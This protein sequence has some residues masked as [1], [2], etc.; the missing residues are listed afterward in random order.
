VPETYSRQ[1]YLKHLLAHDREVRQ[2][3]MAKLEEVEAIRDDLQ[4]KSNAFRAAALKMEEE[5]L[6]LESKKEQ[7]RKLL[8]KLTEQGESYKENL[9][10]LTQAKKS[11]QSLLKNLRK[12]AWLERKRRE[13][14]R[15]K[16]ALSS[17]AN[18][19]KQK[20][21]LEPPVYGAISK[22]TASGKKV[23]GILISAPW[24]SD[25]RAFFDGQVI[26]A[27]SLK[28]YGNVII[29]DHGDGFMSLVAQLSVLFKQVGDMVHEGDVIG[30]SGSGPWIDEGVYFELRWEN[31]TL[32]PIPWL[33]PSLLKVR[34]LTRK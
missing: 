12:K 28:G 9:A 4:F 21:D 20:G 15:L 25:V 30:L 7:K 24:G 32:N 17:G 11:L 16:A 22:R 27:G 14:Q 10:E 23:R 8:Q 13:Q 26:Y 1:A 31:K 5:A 2:Q 6:Q 18:L 33:N 3:Y 34:S 29:V 19:V